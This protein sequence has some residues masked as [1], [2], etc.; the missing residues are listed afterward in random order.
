MLRLRHNP[1][2]TRLRLQCEQWREA[3]HDHEL[4]W[5]R[6]LALQQELNSHLTAIPGY[7]KHW[8]TVHKAWDGGRH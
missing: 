8:K 5:Q 2:N 4:A 6:V 3:H 1:A 7:I